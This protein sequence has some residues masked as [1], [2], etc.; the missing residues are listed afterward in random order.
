MTTALAERPVSAVTS[1]ERRRLIAVDQL[2]L[3]AAPTTASCARMFVEFV[4]RR[5]HLPSNHLEN[6]E[7]LAAELVS[8]ATESRK[9]TELAS[10]QTLSKQRLQFIGLRLALFENG[11]V[12][13]VWDSDPHPPGLPTQPE[14][15]EQECLALVAQ[16][17]RR[18]NYYPAA[19]G[20]VVWCELAL[21]PASIEDATFPLPQQLPCR[22]R[23][24]GPVEPI[25][26]M[27]DPDVLKRLL[28][29]LHALDDFGGHK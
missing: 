19:S 5:W 15:Q 26:V 25:E 4:F 9:R 7:R 3:V 16:L 29:G 6:A 24:D 2:R 20:K 1:Q 10:E 18:W 17:A 28:D 23:Y 12:I 8:H 13:E 22:R 14:R 11:L 27:S 21:E